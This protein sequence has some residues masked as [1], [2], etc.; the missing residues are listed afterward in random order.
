MMTDPKLQ[1]VRQLSQQIS[2]LDK[3]NQR[4]R[5]EVEITRIQLNRCLKIIEAMVADLPE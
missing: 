1:L 4:L 3:E 5:Q 2:L